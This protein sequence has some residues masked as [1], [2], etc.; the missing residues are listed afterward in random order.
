[1]NREGLKS[2]NTSYKAII[3]TL[4]LCAVIYLYYAGGSITQLAAIGLFLGVL[5]VWT[6][7]IESF[8]DFQL[9]KEQWIL[10]VVVGVLVGL[11]MFVAYIWYK[12]MDFSTITFNA[13]IFVAVTMV[14][15]AEEFFFRGYLQMKLSKKFGIVSRIILVTVLFGLYKVAV[16]SSMRTPLSLAEIVVISCLGSVIL[17]VQ[18]EKMQNLLAPLISHVLWDN[19]VYSNMAD[20]PSWIIIS[21]QWTETLYT[22]MYRFSGIFCSQWDLSS[23]AIAGRQFVTCSGCTGIFLGV[24]FAFFL[25]EKKLF[26]RLNTK[27]FYIPALLP[28][29]LM[30]FG[31]NILVWTGMLDSYQLTRMQLQVINYCYTFFGL[32]LGFSGSVL[33]INIISEQGDLWEKRMDRWLPSYEYVA[34]PALLLAFLSNPLSNPQMTALVFFSILVVIGIVTAVVFVVILIVSGIT[35]RVSRWS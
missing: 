28:Q 29:I 35:G 17:S 20:V 32:L 16:F 14:A 2:M 25:Y 7:T 31:L 6:G 23:Y 18:M 12:Q 5:Y 34:I 24:F 27:K 22:Y 1:M 13:S 19:L 21:P 30:F 33:M 8:Q 4:G 11:A 15:A 10:N 3:A 9:K 26:Q